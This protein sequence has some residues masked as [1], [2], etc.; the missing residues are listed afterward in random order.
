M[1]DYKILVSRWAPAI[2]IGFGL[3]MVGIGAGLLSVPTAC[4]RSATNGI[5]I[6]RLVEYAVG[7]RAGCDPLA[8]FAELLSDDAIYVVTS[9]SSYDTGGRSMLIRRDGS[10]AIYNFFEIEPI[11][12]FTGSPDSFEKIAAQIA[13]LMTFSGTTPHPEYPKD[14]LDLRL[15]LPALFCEIHPSNNHSSRTF[16]IYDPRFGNG[17]EDKLD[18]AWIRDFDLDC[19]GPAGASL[20]RRADLVDAEVLR[21]MRANGLE[22]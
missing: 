4:Y 17:G 14:L 19:D 2:M 15:R 16:S 8:R 7:E 6:D 9:W 13:P 5:E 20:N 11:G 12:T 18:D 22:R 3:A 21:V 1:G 10:G